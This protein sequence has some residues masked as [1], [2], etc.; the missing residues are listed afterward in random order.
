MAVYS[1]LDLARLVVCRIA[2]ELAQRDAV[3]GERV[4]AWDRPGILAAAKDLDLK[5][6]EVE[7]ALVT[8]PYLEREYQLAMRL[9]FGDEQ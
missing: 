7:H 4:F 8:W 2:T 1:E 9:A 3:H 5:A 6:D